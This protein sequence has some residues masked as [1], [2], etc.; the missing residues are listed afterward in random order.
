MRAEQRSPDRATLSPHTCACGSPFRVLDRVEGREQDTLTVATARGPV[1]LHPNVFH[2]ALD[3]LNV[4]GWQV[5]QESR[6][7]LR[8]LLV[9]GAAPSTSSPRNGAWPPPSPRR[10][11]D[12]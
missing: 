4:A 6:H 5:V 11:P 7:S 1:S 10:G 9:P 3:D 8:L 12:R 2:A